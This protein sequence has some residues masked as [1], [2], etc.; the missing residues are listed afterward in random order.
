MLEI[1]NISVNV[2][3]SEILHDVSFKA[4]PGKNICLLGKNGSGKS[5][6]ALAVMGHPD[7]MVTGGD[8]LIDGESILKMEPNERAQK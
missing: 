6:L 7:Y 4:V 1:Q 3:D 2:D 8:I 5:S